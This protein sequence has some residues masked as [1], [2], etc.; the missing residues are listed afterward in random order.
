MPETSIRG[1]ALVPRE[2]ANRANPCPNTH[3][4]SECH[5]PVTSATKSTKTTTE[6]TSDHQFNPM[7]PRVN[8]QRTQRRP[9]TARSHRTNHSP[10]IQTPVTARRPISRPGTA[11]RTSTFQVRFLHQPP[12]RASA[13]GQPLWAHSL[14]TQKSDL[15]EAGQGYLRKDGDRVARYVDRARKRP[16]SAPP[17]MIGASMTRRRLFDEGKCTFR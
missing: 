5:Y 4:T 12:L 15:G 8:I 9:A 2:R 10:R 3:K 11:V 7:P 13:N 14:T 16:K 6:R 1:Y 17:D